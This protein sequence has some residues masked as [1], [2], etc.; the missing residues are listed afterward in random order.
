MATVHIV[1][2]EV[3]NRAERSGATIPVI[4]SI[5]KSVETIT[6]TVTSQPSTI[7]TVESDDFWSVTATGGNVWIEFGIT[8]VA[9]PGRGWLI[10]N[11]ETR[12]FSAS[13]VGEKLAIRDV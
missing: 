7:E 12:E 2:A 11:G 4:K 8:P 13:M 3:E 5:P 10:L 9:A 6:T 1:I